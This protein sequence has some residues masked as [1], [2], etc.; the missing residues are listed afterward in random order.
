MKRL[1][2]ACASLL[3]ALLGLN[4]VH[5]QSD[6]IVTPQTANPAAVIAGVTFTLT[7]DF[8]VAST[9]VSK[10]TSST[11]MPVWTLSAT[12]VRSPVAIPPT[13]RKVNLTYQ[14]GAIIPGTTGRIIWKLNGRAYSE[15]NFT[16]P[17]AGVP[18]S[19]AAVITV[20]PVPTAALAKVQIAFREY[21]AI[22]GQKE[23]FQEGNRIILEASAE[24]VAV[25]QIFPQ[26]PLPVASLNFNL[27]PQAAGDYTAVFKFNG[28][29]LAEKV[30]RIA[31]PAPPVAATVTSTFGVGRATRVLIRERVAL[32][33]MVL[34]VISGVPGTVMS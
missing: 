4:S 6:V 9:D 17:P 33:R 21:A 13:P 8:E 27:G 12:T 34:P 15:S 5:A 32:M 28:R 16:V 30:F 3:F 29:I 24:R 26:P 23:A 19:A 14:L 31:N 7:T 25:I 2:H 10:S 20:D 1:L 22:T 18:I 11:G